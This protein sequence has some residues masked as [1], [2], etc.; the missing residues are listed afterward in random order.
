MRLGNWLQGKLV[1]FNSEGI[2]INTNEKREYFR[3]FIPEVL[4]SKPNNKELIKN[5]VSKK[6]NNKLEGYIQEEKR[7]WAE[8]SDGETRVYLIKDKIGEVALFFSLKCGLLV[9]DDQIDKLSDDQQLF[10]DAVIEMMYGNDEASLRNMHD[11]GESMEIFVMVRVKYSFSCTC[12]P[13][14]MSM[15][16][17]SIPG[18]VK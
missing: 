18:K 3:G 6:A 17:T 1:W 12:P 16:S 10:V 4:T 11:A 9:G 13:S 7:A 14:K 2:N 15:L 8:D 5:F